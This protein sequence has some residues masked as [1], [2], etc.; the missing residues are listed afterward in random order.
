M[1]IYT[2]MFLCCVHYAFIIKGLD[3]STVSYI[4]DT[5][6]AVSDVFFFNHVHY[7]RAQKHLNF[8]QSIEELW[9][10]PECSL[11]PCLVCNDAGIV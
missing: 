9:P 1:M 3:R 4:L 8:V 6:Y 11:C 7:N 2:C 10:W 5:S